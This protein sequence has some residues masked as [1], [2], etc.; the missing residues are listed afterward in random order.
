MSKFRTFHILCGPILCALS[1]FL[2]SPTFSVKA[3]QAMGISIWMIYWWISRPVNITVTALVPVIANAILNVI[4]MAGIISRYSSESIILIFGSGLLTVPWPSIGLDR[5]ISLKVLSLIGPDMKSQITVWLLTSIVLSNFMPNVVVCALLTPIAIAML[6]AAGY[7]GRSKIAIPILCAIGWGVG[8][9]G[10]GT[11]LGGAM[12][13]TAI[14]ILQE[15]TGR[16]F[17]YIDW[18]THITPFTILATLVCLGMMLFQKYEAK[19]LQGSKEYFKQAYQE[20]GPIKKDEI[21]CLF[22]FTIGIMAVFFRPLY[23]T[24]LPRMVPAYVFLMLGFLCFFLVSRDHNAPLMTWEEAQKETMWGM[25][26]LFAGGLAMGQ[27]LS[28]SGAN[29]EISKL[30][31]SLHLKG[32]LSV[33]ILITVM[34][35]LI[36]EATNSTVSAAVTVPLVINLAT[37]LHLNIMTYWYIAI[38]AFNAEFL[39]P[40]SVRCIPVSYGLDP[41]DMFKKALPIFLARN[42]LVII[43]SYAFIH[44]P[45]Y[46]M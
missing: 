29:S 7:S 25:M 39:L 36:S 30:M 22:L 12:N 23:A 44:L 16:E 38:I 8:I 45:F 10:V 17:M 4:P 35:S 34:A 1:I 9:G 27:L 26:I 13:I 43:V 15:F 24:L 19:S 28:G 11:P 33:I 2:L 20:L 14:A 42:I 3:A 40:V 31:S 37:E 41:K 18:M 32:G 46:A 5:R 6:E 21:T